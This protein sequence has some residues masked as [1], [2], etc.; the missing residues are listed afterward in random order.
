MSKQTNKGLLITV[1]VLLTALLALLTVNL[2]KGGIWIVEGLNGADGQNGQDGL[3]AYELAQKDG[4]SGTLHEWLVSLAIPGADGKDGAP[5]MNGTNGANGADG[6]GV[7]DVRINTEGR[8]LVTLTNGLVLDAGAVGGGGEG[9]PSLGENV[10]ADGYRETYEMVLQTGYDDLWLRLTPDIENGTRYRAVKRDT[11]LLRIGINEETGYS[12]F[13]YNGTVCYAK[14][15]NFEIK[16]IYS[17][18]IPEVRLPATLALTRGEA[19]TFYTDRIVP[20]LP[21]H[22]K[23]GFSYTGEAERTYDGDRSFSVK[24]TAVGEGTLTFTLSTEDAGVWQVIYRHEIAVTVVEA[25]PTLSLCG[26]VIGDGRIAGG[27]LAEALQAKRPNLRF[28]GTCTSP[29]TSVPHEGRSGWTTEELLT[30]ASVGGVTNPFYSATTAGFDFSHYMEGNYPG[31]KPDFVV[32]QL[33]LEDVYSAAAMENINK[34]VASIQAYAQAKGYQIR[35]MVLSEYLVDPEACYLSAT[36]QNWDLHALRQ[37]Q[38]RAYT[39]QTKLFAGREADGVLLLPVH[40]IIGEIKD[41]SSSVPAGGTEARVNDPLRLS[42]LGTEQVADL[43]CAQ[44]QK[45]D[46]VG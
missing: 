38:L 12:R 11:E 2:V 39:H 13:L 14:S 24:P 20:L 40:A 25:S 34:M 22:I 27:E 30:R 19:V 46:G 28:L 17:G 21:D 10:D 15:R 37:K 5:G 29:N 18:E 9:S 7:R 26:L 41:F 1:I 16:Y 43:I 36:H 32:L 44:I 23:P 42:A 8:L 4:F 3:S 45:I 33:G 35:V 6:V 31:E